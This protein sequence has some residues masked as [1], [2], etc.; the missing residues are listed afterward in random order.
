MNNGNPKL[1]TPPG[2]NKS[3]IDTITS[4]DL[5]PLY[6][7][8]TESDIFDSNFPINIAIGSFSCPRHVFL[9][10]LILDTDKANKLYHY[11]LFTSEKFFNKIPMNSTETYKYFAD[12]LRNLTRL[13]FPEKQR[14]PRSVPAPSEGRILLD[15]WKNVSVILNHRNAAKIYSS[16]HLLRISFQESERLYYDF[17]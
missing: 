6:E 9:Y 10:K 8:P 2:I 14:L 16:A 4:A 17:I 12:H 3:V 7:I 15:G 1:F 11:L 13:L 5:A